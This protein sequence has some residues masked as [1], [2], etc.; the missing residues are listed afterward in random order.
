MNVARLSSR[1]ISK[2][3]RHLG[4]NRS[5]A[6]K[7]PSGLL[8]G[9]ALAVGALAAC[10]LVNRRLAAKAERD[11]PP[12]GRF[13]EVD[14]VRLH[15]VDRGQGDVLVLMHGNGSMIEDFESSGLLGMAAERYRVIAFDRPG[16]GHSERPRDTV[17]T[18]EE[19]AE[20]INRALVQLGVSRAVVLGHSRGASVAAALALSHPEMVASL[21]LASG[22][23]YTKPRI[24]VMLASA[25]AVPLFGD[26]LRHTL[27][28]IAGRLLWPAILRK[29]FGPA[30]VPS[31]FRTFPREM[32]LRPSQLRAAAEES[33]LML[34]GGF[35]PPGSYARIKAPV[36]IVTGD[37]DQ[38][39]DR[40][41]QSARLHR[42]ITQSTLRCIPRTGHM[43]HQN[44]PKQVLLAIDEAASAGRERQTERNAA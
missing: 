22:Y 29:L 25:P 8:W 7:A 31:K 30:D 26:V 9:T 28:P 12:R 19:Q 20:L 35:A 37:A 16:F 4:S 1:P 11:N 5:A 21:V 3:I 40:D 17:W 15:Y 6:P 13:I 23:Y 2:A 27:A 43:V 39:V 42:E 41:G 36:V 14:G 33:A 24:D 10:A 32:A 18:P 44:A 38:V 34:P